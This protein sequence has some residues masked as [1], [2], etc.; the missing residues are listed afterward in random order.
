[1]AGCLTKADCMNSI[2]PFCPPTGSKYRS[3][4]RGH[5]HQQTI[6]QI[7]QQIIPSHQRCVAYLHSMENKANFLWQAESKKDWGL[8]RQL[9]KTRSRHNPLLK[10]ILFIVPRK[11]K[12]II[13][14]GE[15]QH[16]PL[17]GQG[18]CE[19]VPELLQLL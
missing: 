2:Y 14:N 7:S 6:L 17:I 3:P 19:S 18:Q 16:S 15:I 8:L 9:Y 13:N 10:N 1:M 11:R 5:F 12:P 4:A